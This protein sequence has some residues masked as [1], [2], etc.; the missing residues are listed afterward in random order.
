MHAA[1]VV[2]PINPSPYLPTSRRFA[3][4]LYL[5]VEDI[6]STPRLPSTRDE[7]TGPGAGARGAGELIDRDASWAAKLAALRAA[8][9]RPG[10]S[11]GRR[12]AFAAFAAR[13]AS[14]STGSP[15]G[16]R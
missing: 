9:S 7:S 16:A 5:R 13:R 1:E 2:A 15:R 11:P 8:S 12:A 10:C 14:R 6:P 4:P 3:N